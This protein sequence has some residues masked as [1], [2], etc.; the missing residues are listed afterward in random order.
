MFLYKL[1]WIILHRN[2]SW[3]SASNTL[4]KVHTYGLFIY[5]QGDQLSLVRTRKEGPGNWVLLQ[6]SLQWKAFIWWLWSSWRLQRP[7]RSDFLGFRKEKNKTKPKKSLSCFIASE[8]AEQSVEEILASL[9]L[10]GC[11]KTNSALQISHFNAVFLPQS[12]WW[13]ALPQPLLPSTLSSALFQ[14]HKLFGSSQRL[15]QSHF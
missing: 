8:W 4:T 1:M 5:L 10:H 7:D 6:P 12:P 3:P 14:W 15:I 9:Q 2:G 11:W 13:Q